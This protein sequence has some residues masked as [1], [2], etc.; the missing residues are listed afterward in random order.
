MTTNNNSNKQK[1]IF[2]MNEKEILKELGKFEIDIKEFKKLR[3]ISIHQWSD[4]NLK[5]KI[6]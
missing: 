3:N 1:D 6:I 4:F 2:S 5:Q